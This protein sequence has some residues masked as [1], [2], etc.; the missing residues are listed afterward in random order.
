MKSLDLSVA[1]CT[2]NG[3]DRLPKVLERL[4]SQV[5]TE[6]IAWEIIIVDNNSSDRTSEVVKT[7][8]KDWPQPDSIHYLF[9]GKQGA[10]F[11]RQ[12]AIQN[13][14]SSLICLLDDDNLPDENWISAAYKFAQEHPKA[15][16][17]N[18]Q[19]HGEFEVE[20]PEEF[21]RLSTY[22]AI[23][24]R[25]S[26]PHIYTPKR[27]VL[28]PTAGL[29]IRREAWLNA[30]PQQQF[31]VG[32]TADS[33]LASEDIE[34][35]AHVQMQGW[36]IWYNPEMHLYHQIPEWRLERDY[37]IKLVRGVGLAK[38]HIRM[39]RLKDWQRPIAFPVF[40]VNDLIK[41]TRHS[42]QYRKVI[43][44]DL[45]AACELELLKSSVA[46]PFYLWNHRLNLKRNVSYDT[47]ST[48]SRPG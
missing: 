1:I 26:K 31:L 24:E 33:M 40:L 29:V 13:A 15:G 41:L 28:P 10:A 42:I 23:I 25:G 9:E 44:T 5:N 37:L 17:F 7:Y 20:P 48:Q 43:K 45:F 2:Y 39:I 27:R 35:V 8:Q 46:S 18:G 32:R 21:K 16:A 38:H 30:V 6:N 11:A 4:R 36:E 3:A 34:A 22:L 47:D 19:I 12:T 14:N